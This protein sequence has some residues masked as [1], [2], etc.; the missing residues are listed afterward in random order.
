[1]LIKELSKKSNIKARS[2]LCSPTGLICYI[3]DGLKQ[4][5]G[6][7]EIADKIRNYNIPY[8][9]MLETINDKELI[10]KVLENYE[11]IETINMVYNLC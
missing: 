7:D 1:M 9:P 6:V 3:V 5:L 11:N 2:L 10:E 8:N 4:G